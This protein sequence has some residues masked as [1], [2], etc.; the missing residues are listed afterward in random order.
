MRINSCGFVP[1]TDVET[2]L[3]WALVD[4]GREADIVFTT[5][6]PSYPK[7][8]WIIFVCMHIWWYLPFRLMSSWPGGRSCWSGDPPGPHND[9]GNTA[10]T[11]YYWSQQSCLWLD[12]LSD[13]LWGLLQFWLLA[14]AERGGGFT[15]NNSG[16]FTLMWW[17]KGT[18]LL[19]W[20]WTGLMCASMHTSVTD[21]T[22]QMLQPAPLTLFT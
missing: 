7:M 18:W 12:K 8:Q 21:E 14:E 5:G 13:L 20:L 16:R 1:Q 10:C 4:T 11:V 15:V 3:W 22:C 9:G 2:E 6:Q 17:S 19:A